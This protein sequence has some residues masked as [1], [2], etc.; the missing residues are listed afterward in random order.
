MLL[1]LSLRA[2]EAQAKQCFSQS[3]RVDRELSCTELLQPVLLQPQNLGILAG[4]RAKLGAG[5]TPLRNQETLHVLALTFSQTPVGN[6]DK[7]EGVIGGAS[8]SKGGQE[9]GRVENG[10][11]TIGWSHIPA[12]WDA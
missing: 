11:R 7:A 4:D 9:A 1:P 6:R 12:A 3:L 2:A 10:V 5:D 8:P